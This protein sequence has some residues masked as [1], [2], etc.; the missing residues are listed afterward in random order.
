MQGKN[1][2]H[3]KTHYSAVSLITFKFYHPLPFKEPPQQQKAKKKKKEKKT[4]TTKKIYIPIFQKHTITN[5]NPRSNS[6]NT[7]CFF[8]S[9]NPN[10][11]CP[12]CQ[13]TNPFPI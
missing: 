7:K 1:T 5:N 9:V 8:F 3:C 4:T 12:K 13:C 2:H 10:A 6:K 11:G